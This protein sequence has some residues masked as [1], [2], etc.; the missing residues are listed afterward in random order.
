MSILQSHRASQTGLFRITQFRTNCFVV[1]LILTSTGSAQEIKPWTLYVRGAAP[2]IFNT[3]KFEDNG[4]V[5]VAGQGVS[6]GVLDSLI[7][8]DSS[9]SQRVSKYFENISIS[10]REYGIL[11]DFT[12]ATRITHVKPAKSSFL[13]RTRTQLFVSTK[14]E[15]Q[16]D[17]KRHADAHF[18]W[19]VNGALVN[20]SD[21]LVL[22][23]GFEYGVGPGLDYWTRSM[24]F[25]VAAGYMVYQG[26]PAG[27]INPVVAIN[28]G[29]KTGFHLALGWKLRSEK[30]DLSAATTQSEISIGIGWHRRQK[31]MLP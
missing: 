22:P 25:S 24:G 1:L 4:I 14:Y 8:P 29:S 17:Y 27:F 5:N 19:R 13:V 15:A 10:Q 12:Q 20:G 2:L 30:I 7:A 9:E 3:V 31:A 21:Y 18:L 16:L 6:F 23:V 26:H 11:L 28:L